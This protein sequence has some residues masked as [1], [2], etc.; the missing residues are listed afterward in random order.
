VF[1]IIRNSQPIPPLLDFLTKGWPDQSFSE[2]D[3]GSST[4]WHSN[5][6]NDYDDNGSNENYAVLKKRNESQK[7][8]RQHGPSTQVIK[9]IETKF[10]YLFQIIFLDTI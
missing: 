9:T 5:D 10:F 4:G 7:E 6:D 3:W 2:D 8:C 1:L